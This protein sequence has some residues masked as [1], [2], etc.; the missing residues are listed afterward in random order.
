MDDFGNRYEERDRLVEAWKQYGATYNV[1]V[2]EEQPTPK[3]D[4][5]DRPLPEPGNTGILDPQLMKHWRL[6][7][8][9]RN[10]LRHR[11]AEYGTL[12]GPALTFDCLV[13]K[14]QKPLKVSESKQGKRTKKGDPEEWY[15]GALR[16]LITG[17]GEVGFTCRS[18]ECLR[19]RCKLNL[20]NPNRKS[21]VDIFSVIQIFHGYRSAAKAKEIVAEA[22]DIRLGHFEFKDLEQKPLI[23]RY[24]V[25]KW[26][27]TD[28]IQRFSDMHRQDIPRL[29]EEAVDLVKSSQVVELEHSRVFSSYF[30][31]MWPQII[32]NEVLQKINGASIRLYLWLLVQQEERARRNEF[33]MRLTD[34]ET[35]RA[36]GVSR[37]TAGIY[38]QELEKLGLLRIK[39][40]IWTVGYTPK[41]QRNT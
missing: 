8:A 19:T 30:A 3:G 32:D 35:A 40:G 6:F 13:P 7:T 18:R 36:I 12:Q 11:Y 41:S 33:F 28:L 25:T 26:A 24:A 17:E 20:Q 23:K 4:G 37:K 5:W 38:R 10:F 34:A 22:F 16:M 39:E 1:F 27:V 21:P 14:Y 9:T 2:P 15:A 31:L 29:V